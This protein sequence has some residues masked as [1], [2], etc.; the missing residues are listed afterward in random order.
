MRGT[1]AGVALVSVLLLLTAMLVMALA[2]Q[3]M[4]LLGFLTTR[5]QI[6]FAQ[7]EAAMHSRLTHSLLMLE[8][9]LVAGT[10]ELPEAPLMPAGTGYTR[11]DEKHARLL[12]ED[13][14][15]PRLGMEVIVELTGGTTQVILRR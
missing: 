4:A 3:M 1:R 6:A 8:S 14:E 13:P 12:I 10:G 11:L 2:V 7:S 9:Q 15:P 5:N